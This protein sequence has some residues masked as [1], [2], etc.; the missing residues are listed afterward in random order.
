MLSYEHFITEYGLGDLAGGD[1]AAARFVANDDD[2]AGGDAASS[3][4]LSVANDDDDAALLAARER[5][6]LAREERRLDAEER[7]GARLDLRLAARLREIEARLA[8]LDDDDSEADDAARQCRRGEERRS[9]R[10]EGGGRMEGFG[11]LEAARAPASS[12]S[13]ASSWRG[14]VECDDTNDNDGSPP[15]CLSIEC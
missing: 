5:T 2:L 10:G 6:A 7:D 13:A 4:A 11:A 14:C 1:A 8:A 12:P 9:P 15:S 3:A